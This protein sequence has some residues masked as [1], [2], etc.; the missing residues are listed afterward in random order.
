MK[1]RVLKFLS[2]F[3]RKVSDI[4][5]YEYD[6]IVATCVNLINVMLLEIAF[7]VLKTKIKIYVFKYS[8]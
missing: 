6:I 7:T 5:I 2:Y 8:K 4:F 3:L 1:E